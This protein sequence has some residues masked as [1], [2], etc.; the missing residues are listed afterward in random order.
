MT[1]IPEHLLERTRSRRQA[2]GLPVSGGDDAAPASAAA[3]GGGAVV[4]AGGAAPVPKGPIAPENPAEVVVAAP[5]PTPPYIEAA[6]RRRR[7]PYWALP[8]L[9]LMPVWAFI[10]AGTLSPVESGGESFL[11]VGGEIYSSNCASCHGPSGGGVGSFPPLSD[12]AVL[13]T[14]A[15]P[16][17]QLRWVTL[18]SA[19][20]A[21]DGVYGDG[22][23]PST[24]GMPAFGDIL[25][26][27]ELLL[28]VRH[29]REVL[30]GEVPDQEAWL[31]GLDEKGPDTGLE[32]GRV[33]HLL[34]LIEVEHIVPA[35]GEA[36]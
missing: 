24:G 5:A 36:E 25:T 6:E 20:G 31:T 12:G 10:Y 4:A 7:V 1:E 8:V 34:E 15:N 28:V 16:V 33:D 3:A 35:E 18:G 11:D 29:E 21:V 14:F 23:K 9:A 26:E 32:A 19:G 13:Q 22:G 17:D 2:L 30:S 27:E